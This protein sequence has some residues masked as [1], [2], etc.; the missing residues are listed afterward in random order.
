M[1][2]VEYLQ[3]IR[4]EINPNERK[5]HEELAMGTDRMLRAMIVARAAGCTLAQ[6]TNWDRLRLVPASG[7]VSAK[8]SKVYNDRR[9]FTAFCV[10]HL[11]PAALGELER[12]THFLW[13]S[14]VFDF[15]SIDEEDQVALVVE[16][17]G[18]TRLYYVRGIDG[19]PIC[20]DETGRRIDVP[21]DSGKG[22]DG[23]ITNHRIWLHRAYWKWHAHIAAELRKQDVAAEP[24]EEARAA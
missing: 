4:T 18:E 24:A 21:V 22:G 6:L 10:A 2:T 16:A 9:A 14:E 23:I 8:Q 11:R 12:L 15:D 1:D 19:D 3:S 7:Y 20:M 17:D 13:E 5:E